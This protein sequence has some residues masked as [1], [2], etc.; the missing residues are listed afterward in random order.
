MEG[1]NT[2]R[3]QLRSHI[4]HLLTWSPIDHVWGAIDITLTPD[5][6]FPDWRNICTIKAAQT[7]ILSIPRENDKLRLYVNL[8]LVDGVVDPA[9]GRV[10]PNGISQERFLE[11]NI[12]F[13]QRITVSQSWSISTGCRG[14]V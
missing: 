3:Y 2:G 1:E 4:F 5:S 6:N 12:T 13:L 9:T 10:A 7:T 14:S 8:G 11:V